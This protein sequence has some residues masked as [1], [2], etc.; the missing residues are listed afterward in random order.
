MIIVFQDDG[1]VCVLETVAQANRDY[2]AI[3]VENGEYT[4]LDERGFVLKPVFRSPSKKKLFF[5]FS[6]AEA[7]PFTFEQTTEKRDELLERL[8]RG[9]IPIDNGPTQIRTLDDLRSA[10][11]LL[12]TA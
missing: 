4:L 9:E 12:F 2:E 7:G 5:F 3:D 8:R 10:A 11:P 1:T 6:I